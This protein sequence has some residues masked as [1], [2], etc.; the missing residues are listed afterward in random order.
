M[1]MKPNELSADIR[2]KLVQ[3]PPKRD[4][5]GKVVPMAL[6]DSEQEHM[7]FSMLAGI[8]EEN[9]KKFGG[10][11]IEKNWTKMSKKERNKGV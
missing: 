3:N 10:A 11:F 1:T 8:R 7:I 9:R 4:S 5:T 2:K 6:T